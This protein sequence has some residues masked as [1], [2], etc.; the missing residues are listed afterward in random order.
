[1]SDQPITITPVT[2]KVGVTSEPVR[3]SVAPVLAKITVS[4]TPTEVRVTPR[5]VS[6]EVS[7]GLRG[8][9]GPK[10]DPGPAG[11]SGGGTGGG[12]YAEYGF[13]S[14]SKTW[15]I[16]HNQGT[17]GMVVETVDQ[18]GATVIGEVTYPDVD[19]VVVSFYYPASGT[20]RVFN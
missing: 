8:P 9:A 4:P 12:F 5:K 1:V 20:A 11:S 18:A 16:N 14:P 7:T 10:G 6:V 15:V 19:T 2:P 3:V 13:A 17:F